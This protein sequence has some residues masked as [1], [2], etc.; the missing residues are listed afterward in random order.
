MKINGLR[1]VLQEDSDEDE[2]PGKSFRD[3]PFLL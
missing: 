1:D 2:E 3:C